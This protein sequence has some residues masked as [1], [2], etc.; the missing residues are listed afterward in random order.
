M[1]S[2]PWVQASLHP[3]FARIC[4]PAPDSEG[5]GDGKL[6]PDPVITLTIGKIDGY[7]PCRTAP[8]GTDPVTEVH[9][10]QL[11]LV[12]RVAGVD[13]RGNAP[14]ALVPMDVFRTGHGQIASA[15]RRASFGHAKALVSVAAHGLGATGTKQEVLGNTVPRRRQR[16]PALRPENQDIPLSNREEVLVAPIQA[17]KIAVR[18]ESPG[19]TAKLEIHHLPPPGIENVVHRPI[20][21]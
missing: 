20:G 3:G 1:K 7:R 8:A 17:H 13:K 9:L 4:S 16:H 12:V 21:P 14:V 11:A 2:G 18:Q 5:D 19:C 15:H 10:E 6:K